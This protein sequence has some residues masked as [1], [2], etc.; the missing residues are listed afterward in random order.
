LLTTREVDADGFTTK[1]RDWNKVEVLEGWR[2]A[3]ARDSNAALVLRFG[4]FDTRT[5]L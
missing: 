2:E 5:F 4:Y 3:W 1:N